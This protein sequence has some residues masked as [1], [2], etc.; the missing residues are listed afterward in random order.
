M[1]GECYDM[2]LADHKPKKDWQLPTVILVGVGMLLV[3]GGLIFALGRTQY[4]YNRFHWFWLNSY[5]YA[6]KHASFVVLEG[7]D[8]CPQ[9]DSFESANNLF[10]R[11]R[12]RKVPEDPPGMTVS[13][14]D[15]SYSCYWETDFADYSGGRGAEMKPGVIM[16]Y[17]NP[18]G[19]TYCVETEGDYYL[20]RAWLRGEVDDFFYPT[21]T[22]LA[23][24]E[25]SRGETP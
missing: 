8:P 9:R 18:A 5:L 7:D 4:L 3:M 22:E 11:G 12:L 19:K 17:T 14:G 15:G 1:A 20:L 6:Q 2:V 10:W 24:L 23:R 13:Y 25:E 16:A 21:E